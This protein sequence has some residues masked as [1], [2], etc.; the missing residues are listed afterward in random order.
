[1]NKI[2]RFLNSWM[3]PLAMLT[4]AVLYKF[5]SHVAFLTPYLIFLMLFVTFSKIPF[6]QMKVRPQHFIL[7]AFQ[8]IV[9]LFVYICLH[10]I[11]PLLAQGAFICIF[12]PTATAAPVITGMLNGDIAF[13]TTYSL[14]C[15]ILVA[16][17]APILFT[18]IGTCEGSSFGESV[19]LLGM[20]VLPVLFLPLLSALLI[21]QFLPR[22]NRVITR[23]P[24]LAFYLWAFAIVIVIGKTVNFIIEQ[25][26]N[27]YMIEILLAFSAL[28]ICL[29]QFYI[30]RK[31]GKRFGDA[32][33]SG[34]AL[35]QKNTILAIW[36]AQ[37]YLNPIT[38]LAPAAYVVWQNCL[39]S[40]QLMRHS[41]KEKAYSQLNKLN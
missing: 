30:G 36:M 39:N 35:G 27:N 16:I 1:M 26:G 3:L 6:S 13:L 33:S 5:I 17:L 38:S 24:K 34:Q 7:L 40:Y 14:L 12:A 4:G 37:A 31:F 19:W 8:L 29:L 10:P 32:V 11:N 18:F 22:V 23:V 15:N 28:I 9:S 21:R 41:K 20:E 2:L 25:N